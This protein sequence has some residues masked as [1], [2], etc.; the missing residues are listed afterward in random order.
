M[1]YAVALGIVARLSQLSDPDLIAGALTLDLTLLVP[2][3]YC[4]LLVR[5]RGWPLVSVLPVFLGSVVLAGRILP[6]SHHRVLD[7]VSYAAVLSELG[8]IALIVYKANQLRRGFRERSAMGLDAYES[9]REAAC[10][11]LGAV[12]GGALAYEA[13]V[14]GYALAG[15]GRNAE[16]G[17]G[18]YSTHRA[19]AY[20]PFMVAAMMAV[21]IETIA[22]HLLLRLWSPTAAWILTAIS[23]YTLLW[24]IGDVHAVR[25]RPIRVEDGLLRLRLGLRWD[26]T[27]P[28]AAIAAVEAPG[29]DRDTDARGDLKAV[30]LGAPNCRIRLREPVRAVGLYGITRSVRIIDLHVDDPAGFEAALRSEPD[31]TEP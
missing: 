25:L 2:G 19:I 24:L 23:L 29:E 12:A 7:L 1:I 28:L 6:S 8:L 27:I 20:V 11:T 22:V 21:G 30:L 9:L 17:L 4:L 13:T 5:G 14:L 3:L 18:T 31:P 16:P 10:S 26:A 15:W